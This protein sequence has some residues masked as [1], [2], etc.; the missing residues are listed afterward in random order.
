MKRI[1]TVLRVLLFL[2]I[3]ESAF[4]IHEYGHLRE[5]RKRDIPVKEFSLGIG[6]LVY[7]YQTASLAVSFRLIPVMAYVAPTEE[8]R[9]L[10]EK[11]GSLWDKIA[12]YTAGVRNNFLVGLTIVLFLQVLGWRKGN[13]SIRELAGTAVV[14]PFKILLRFFAFLVGCITWGRVN[15]AEK[16]L[17]STGGID[18]PKPLKQFI[19]WNLALGL[20]NFAPIPPLDGGHAAQAI[21]LAA[22]ADIYVPHIPIPNWMGIILFAAYYATANNQDMRLLEI[23]PRSDSMEPGRNT[24]KRKLRG[25]LGRW[26]EEGKMASAFLL[27][28]SIVSARLLSTRVKNFLRDSGIY[29]IG[30]LRETT[31]KQLLQIRGFG[32]KSLAEVEAFLSQRDLSLKPEKSE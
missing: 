8:G 16:L 7:Q 3:L 20:F 24:R 32:P 13:L 9:N 29:T 1:K 22:G 2:L 6:P 11:Q 23:E 28:S 10:F 27:E 21:L 19:F 15:L 31:A 30:E 14:T 26:E 12:V 18:P 17:L 5:F 25:A 4:A